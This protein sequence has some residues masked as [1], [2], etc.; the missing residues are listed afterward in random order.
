M[1]F[2]NYVKNK[3][4][5][6][7]QESHEKAIYNKQLE[8]TRKEASRAARLRAAK[9]YAGRHAAKLEKEHYAPQKSSGSIFNMDSEFFG[10]MGGRPS[11]S[12]R[13]K[14]K[15]RASRQ[16]YVIVKGHAYPVGKKA[17]KHKRGRSKSTRNDPFGFGDMGL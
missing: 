9:V 8:Q 7:K 2:K 11:R 5:A 17:S 16:G 14:H 4:A 10:G 13:P 3:Y 15:G 6:Y 1:S 12:S